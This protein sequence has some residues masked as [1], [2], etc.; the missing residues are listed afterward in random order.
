MFEESVAQITADMIESTHDDAL[1]R[2]SDVGRTYGRGD[3]AVVAV[4]GASCTVSP[5]DR[6]A[7]MGPSGSGKSTLLHLLAGLESPTV[8]SVSYPRLAVAGTPGSPSAIGLVFQAPT[9]I[10]SLTVVENVLLPLLLGADAP[11][12]AAERAHA[13]LALLDIDV[14]SNDLPQELSG[15]QAQRVVIARVL[16]S[17]PQVILADEPTSQLDRATADHVADVLVQVADETGA[18]L[19][20]ATHDEA[21]GARM[22]QEWP[23]DDGRLVV[24]P[25]YRNTASKA[26]PAGGHE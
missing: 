20:I 1:I 21:I 24:D 11:S 23:M 9:L 14:L 15:G 16:A 25:A 13:A 17:R 10:P 6:I 7:I 12:D 2:C 8:G 19:V 5:G 4:H 26:C 18:A 22:R 3:S